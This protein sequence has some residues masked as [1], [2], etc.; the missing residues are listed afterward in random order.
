MFDNQVLLSCRWEA[1]MTVKNV[2]FDSLPIW[3]TDMGCTV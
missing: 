3:I 1:G 2:R